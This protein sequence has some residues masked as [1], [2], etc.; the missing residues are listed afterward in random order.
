M[1]HLEKAVMPQELDR[2]WR[3]HLAGG[4]PRGIHLRAYAKNWQEYKREAFVSCA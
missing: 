1:R 4:L 2:H 3:A